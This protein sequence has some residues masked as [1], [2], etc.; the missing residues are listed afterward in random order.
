[1]KKREGEK[2][3]PR[4]CVHWLCS[5]LISNVSIWTQL[6]YGVDYESSA[7]A[8]YYRSF[9]HPQ[10]LECKGAV[11]LQKYCLRRSFLFVYIFHH[12]HPSC[13][14]QPCIGDSLC[15]VGWRQML[16]IQGGK[17]E[18]HKIIPGNLNQTNRVDL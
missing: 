5:G 10:S 2:H 18:E 13:W 11:R 1:M 6:I 14:S 7:L 4:P 3:N 12:T 9:I 15:V 8:L 16:D 17:P